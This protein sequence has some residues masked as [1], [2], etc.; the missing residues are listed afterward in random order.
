MQVKAARDAKVAELD[1]A[2]RGQKH[3]R[4]FDVAVE[5]VATRVQVVQREA[6]LRDYVQD[7]RF[8]HEGD[9]EATARRT[10]H[11][12]NAA[13]GTGPPTRDQSGHVAAVGVL[14]QE[15]ESRGRRAAATP[16]SA[17]LA[18][19][20][21]TAV[22]AHNVWVGARRQHGSLVLRRRQRARI[23]VRDERLLGDKQAAGLADGVHE[24]R[25]AERAAPQLAQ[26]HVPLH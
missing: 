16:A 6:Q 9:A 26:P 12:Q 10:G 1:D 24:P 2:S 23:A 15:D 25:R 7:G 22:R 18:A 17:R 11:A 14:L 4:G 8:G 20:D 21:A 19:L 5:H 13:G 3:V